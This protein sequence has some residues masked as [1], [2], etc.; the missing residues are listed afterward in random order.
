MYL[1]A[2]LD[3]FVPWALLLLRA[4]VGAIFIVHGKAKL[5]AGPAGFAS[6]LKQQGL[7]CALCFAWL[8]SLLEFVGGILLVAGL[9]INPVSALLIINSLVFIKISCYRLRI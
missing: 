7:P 6:M 5:V 8:V 9:F 1:L 4:V 3:V 2:P